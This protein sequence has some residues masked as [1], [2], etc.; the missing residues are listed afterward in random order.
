MRGSPVRMR[1]LV[2]T[3]A[4]VACTNAQVI[5]TDCRRFYTD[6]RL[7]CTDARVVC[8]NVRL[9]CTD[10]QLLYTDAHLVC[11]DARVVY[12]DAQ[13][14]CT[15][16]RVTCN[17]GNRPCSGSAI[18]LVRPVLSATTDGRPRPW[19]PLAQPGVPPQEPMLTTASPE[20]EAGRLVGRVA[21]TRG[22][23]GRR[24]CGMRG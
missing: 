4:R 10:A 22:E 20:S 8:T 1:N 6:A 16:P 5:Y 17:D 7:I 21:G 19:D 11:T 23:A 24:P 15:N 18:D 14:V 2:C 3:R 12:T 13:A 9:V